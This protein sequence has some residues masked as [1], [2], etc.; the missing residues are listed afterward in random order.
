MKNK[1]GIRLVTG[2]GA[3]TLLVFASAATKAA[4]IVLPNATANVSAKQIPFG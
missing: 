4:T 3:A 2:L 1:D